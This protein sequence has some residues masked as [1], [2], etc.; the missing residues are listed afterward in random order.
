M[1]AVE[2]NIAPPQDDRMAY[3]W[4]SMLV[5]DSFFI[6]EADIFKV[7]NASRGRGK[8]YNERYKVGKKT[9]VL[10]DGTVKT[11]CRCWRVA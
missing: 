7:R 4:D 10:A 11:E 9:K 6:D 3:P 5:G 2:H 1:Y 8:R